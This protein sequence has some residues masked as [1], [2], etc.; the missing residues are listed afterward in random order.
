MTRVA[1][2]AVGTLCV[3]GLGVCLWL[4]VRDAL[5]TS[6]GP[7]EQE[8]ARRLRRGLPIDPGDVPTPSRLL[9]R[10]RLLVTTC[11][12]AV[13]SQLSFRLADPPR[14]PSLLGASGLV[15]FG[16]GWLGITGVAVRALLVGRRQGITP[17]SWR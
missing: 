6:G 3:V 1:L 14:S 15:L 9:H 5:R 4:L 2:L 11:T 7:R 16:V 12:F 10:M 13:V 17:H 8:I